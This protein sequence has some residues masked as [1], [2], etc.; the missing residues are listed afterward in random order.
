MTGAED[1]SFAFRKLAIPP[2]R[3]VI[4]HAS[5][6]AFGEVRGGASAVLSALLNSFE[7]IVMPAFTYK[8]MVVPEVGPPD[9]GLVYGGYCDANFMAEFYH[10]DMPSDRLMGVVPESFC[11]QTGTH[12]SSHPILSFVGVNA[13]SILERQ[14]IDE[15]LTPIHCLMQAQGWVL[16]LGVDHTVNTSI[17]LGERLAG[18]KQFVRWALTPGGVLECPHFPGCS[19]GFNQIAPHLSSMIRQ[20]RVGESYILAVPLP[21][22]IAAVKDLLENDPSALLCER[23]YCERCQSVRNSLVSM[24]Q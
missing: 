17:H 9:N 5:L 20:E 22:L 15:P 6:S 21:G 19:D 12:R 2:S 7:A 14:T 18:R 10:S 4:V 8:T 1:F 3:P 23:S 24:G 11:R 13:L 16:L